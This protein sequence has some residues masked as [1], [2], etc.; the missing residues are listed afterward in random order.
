MW[1]ALT[2]VAAAAV[3]LVLVLLLTRRSPGGPYALTAWEYGAI[4]WV[5]PAPEDL[6]GIAATATELFE[7]VFALWGFSP[8]ETI[9]EGRVARKG[10]P[11]GG[12]PVDLRALQWEGALLPPIVVVVFPDAEALAEGTG[13]QVEPVTLVYGVPPQPSSFDEDPTPIE[14]VDW[15]GNLTALSVAFA[16][17]A[18]RWQEQLVEAAAEWLLTRALEIP[19]ICD[20]TPFGLP[21]LVLA[22]IGGFTASRLLGGDDRIAVAM[23][24]AAAE[25]LPTVADVN[26]LVFDVDA[27]T[28]TALGTSFIAYL[29]GEHGTEGLVEAICDWHTGGSS[30]HCMMSASRTL[31]YLKGW[32]AF[33]GVEE[34]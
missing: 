9:A 2:V 20:C 18:A 27:D 30:G 23:E 19:E 1:I 34:E 7:G 5:E 22:G 10:D 8:P 14:A 6:E 28:Y 3:A 17:S 4:A 16:C 21:R 29:V 11:A 13:A 32:R 15:L 26:P 33:L 25:G 24:Y 31:T 12:R